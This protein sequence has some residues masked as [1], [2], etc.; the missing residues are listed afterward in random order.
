MQFKQKDDSEIKVPYLRQDENG[1]SCSRYCINEMLFNSRLTLAELIKRNNR[2]FPDNQT[3]NSNLSNKLRRGSLKD[4]EL[5]QYAYALG[6]KLIIV[7]ADEEPTP[8]IQQ[9]PEDRQLS[10][11]D[12]DNIDNASNEIKKNPNNFD[13]L[14]SLGF[15]AT[16]TPHC[17]EVFIAGEN[18]TEAAEYIS[19]VKFPDDSK[20]TDELRFFIQIENKFKVKIRPTIKK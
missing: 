5:S 20:I 13:E 9:K 7:P 2:L 17:I 6:Y 18:A 8:V 4:Y 14:I 11:F 16:S 19:S 12:N 15:A 10:L 1:E 3:S